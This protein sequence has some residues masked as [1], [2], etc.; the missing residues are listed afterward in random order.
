[1]GRAVLFVTHCSSVCFLERCYD[2]PV[3]LIALEHRVMGGR[4]ALP[5]CHNVNLGP[6]GPQR[7]CNTRC[8]NCVGCPQL[9]ALVLLSTWTHSPVNVLSASVNNTS[10]CH[11]LSLASKDRTVKYRQAILWVGETSRYCS[12]LT[13]CLGLCSH[14]KGHFVVL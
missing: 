8:S 4:R 12:L 13:T 5:H 6:T 14:M 11:P 1:M 10:H 3:S 9:F 2:N 7:E